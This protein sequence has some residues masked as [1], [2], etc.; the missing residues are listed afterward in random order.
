MHITKKRNPR[1]TGIT[2]ETEERQE[3]GKV[4]QERMFMNSSAHFK[5]HVYGS[6]IIQCTKDTEN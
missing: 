5:I 6:D 4:A 1:E 3:L 2:E